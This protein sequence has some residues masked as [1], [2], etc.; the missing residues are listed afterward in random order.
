LSTGSLGNYNLI[1][2]A[3]TFTIDPRQIHIGADNKAKQYGQSDPAFTYSIVSGAVVS[4]DTW[5]GDL[6]RDTGEN[7]GIY[8]ITLGGLTLGDNYVV[9][10]DSGAL[11]INKRAVQV[12]PDAG[13][14]RFYGDKDPTFTFGTN[15]TL[16][17]SETLVGPLGRAAGDNVGDYAFNL[18]DMQAANPNYDLTIDTTNKFKIE[19][20][21]IVITVNNLEK[22][23][24]EA[25][26][27]YT[28]NYTVS[29]SALANGV[30]IVVTGAPTRAVGENVGEYR[31]SVGT[32]SA[33]P[34]FDATIT[35]GA[36]LTIKKVVIHVKASD[37]NSVY[38]SNLPAN[39]VTVTSGTM[40]GS[41]TV[42]GAAYGYST[43]PP[44]HVGTYTITPSTATVAGGLA[45]NYDFVYE[46]GTLTITKADLTVYL[47]KSNSDWGDA[48]AHDGVNHATGLKNSDK[49]G[50]I[51]YTYDGTSTDPSLPGTYA[52]GG[53]V[54]D[55]YLGS[56]DDYNITVVPATYVVNTPFFMS[57]D[58][59]RGPEAG[60]TAFT[61][62]GLGFGFNAPRV[63]FDGLEAT[64][65][66]LVGSSQIS[67]LTPAHV[68]GLVIVTIITDSGTYDFGMVF[69]YYPPVPTPQVNSLG[70]ISGPTSGGNKVT[71]SGSFFP[72]S[73]RKPAK[74][75]VD[76]K[77]ATGIK[78]SKDGKTLE[79]IVPAHA[80]G[81]FDIRV[82]TKDGSFTYP[83]SYEYVP[84]G[85]ST[86]AFIIFGGDSSVL[87]KSG[88]AGLEKLFKKI[89][90]NALVSSIKINGWVH[91]TKST[92]IDA[93]LSYARALVSAK[94]LKLKG[95][96]GTYS[97][98]GMGIYHLGN[99]LD[100]R[101][102]IEVVWTN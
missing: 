91:R 65:V 54:L 96:M 10:V 73:D 44:S 90:K 68:K 46:T 98:K 85:Q 64:S 86:K 51:A 74:I 48:I 6:G 34:N 25:D 53:S 59:A 72:G 100:R 16:P 30:Q 61:I 57:I 15:I 27:T 80:L 26:P 36:K 99:D 23:Y 45:A 87:T 12:K 32:F 5:S 50:N 31:I 66:S 18:G 70:P 56:A 20:L 52:L 24:G 3:G 2:L 37:T 4:G 75:Y 63:L 17:F 35:S 78:V 28:F 60:G 79:M 97:L 89:P 7:V 82:S 41:E 39:S 47:Q 11:T 21:V 76:G 29:A 38:G 58:P 94:Y 22:F 92:R 69:T 49:V 33:G 67:G 43:T 19:K 81:K 13:Q 40:V 93:A 102:E 95:L 71:L 1:Y 42:S 9:T 55:F 77:L 14:K 84:G 62:V 101:A 88:I 83:Q 8:N